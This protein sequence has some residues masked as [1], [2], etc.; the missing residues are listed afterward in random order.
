MIGW[1]EIAEASIPDDVIVQVWRTSNATA[2]AT[3]RG[4]P[5]IV[6]AG[7]YLD[8]LWPATSYYQIDPLNLSASGMMSADYLPEL[9]KN[10]VLAG[11]PLEAMVARQLPPLIETQRELVLGGDAPLWGEGVTDEMLD[12]RLWP[13]AAAVAER[14]WSRAEERNTADM[15]RRLIFVQ[16]SFGFWD[17][18]MMPT[19]GGWRPD[20]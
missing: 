7:Y 17:W 5:V 9:R 3:G 15:Y 8:W 1:E 20:S 4:N 18:T 12:A 10:S 2:S 19:G 14:F 6:S 13:R 16:V 11:L